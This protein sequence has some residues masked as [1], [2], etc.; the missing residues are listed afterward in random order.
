[1]CHNSTLCLGYL[2][3]SSLAG[4]GMSIGALRICRRLWRIAVGLSL[5]V[6]LSDACTVACLFTPCAL[7]CFCLVALSSPSV[8]PLGRD[9]L[10]TVDL[11]TPTLARSSAASLYTNLLC[12]YTCVMDTGAVLYCSSCKMSSHTSWCLMGFLPCVIHACLLYNGKLLKMST[13]HLESLQKHSSWVLRTARIRAL[14]A[15]TSAL[16]MVCGPTTGSLMLSYF[17]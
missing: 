4:S 1:M 2:L 9:I 5:P 13:Y 14:T 16:S 12:P 3:E 7:T 11:A 10:C 17:A 8:G 15:E 6:S